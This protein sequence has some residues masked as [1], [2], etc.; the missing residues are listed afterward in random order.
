MI[1]QTAAFYD[2]LAADY[3]LV[4]TDW[5]SSIRRQA[6]ALDRIIR[7]RLGAT[8]RR[9]LD[10]TCGIGTQSLGLAALGYDVAGTD[11]S[12]RAIQ[13]AR[14]EAARRNLEIRFQVADLRTLALGPGESFDV[15]FSADN[16]LPHLVD[17]SDLEAGIRRMVAHLRPG[18]LLVASIR[19]Y[20][21]ILE[22]PPRGTPPVVT[23]HPGDRRVTFQL[24][25]WDTGHTTYQLE[26]FVLRE[27]PTG[28]W[29][30]E[31]R[32]AR[33]R[34]IRRSELTAIMKE[35]GLTSIQW[36]MRE[37]SGFFQPVVTAIGPG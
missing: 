37:A 9:V 12:S 8:A 22:N 3:H 19:D 2:Q 33:Y 18:G 23:G 29:R 11:L 17:G 30:T 21:A 10:C 1:D 7:D 31:V 32:R 14:S 6:A 34:A 13:R 25:E 4:Y 5:E 15:V 16:S 28:T 26:L 20:D 24:W 27:E 35:Q 36:L